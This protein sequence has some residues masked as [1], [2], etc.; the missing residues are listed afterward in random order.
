VN[1]VRFGSLADIGQPIRDVRFAPESGHVQRQD[2]CPLLAQSRHEKI[3]DF[4]LSAIWSPGR[5]E[6]IGYLTQAP[7]TP[8]SVPGSGLSTSWYSSKMV[9]FT[10]IRRHLENVG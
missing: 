7:H 1:D 2:R 8:G 9:A 10:P 3:W 6:S 4:E 5:Q